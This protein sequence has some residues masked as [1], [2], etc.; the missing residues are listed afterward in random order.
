MKKIVS[1]SPFRIFLHLIIICLLLLFRIIFSLIF[2]FLLVSPFFS[3]S[4]S[5]IRRNLFLLPLKWCNSS[6]LN[7]RLRI[8][9]FSLSFRHFLGSRFSSL[10]LE[11]LLWFRILKHS[12][13]SSFFKPLFDHQ[14]KIRGSIFFPSS[15]SQE[16]ISFFLSSCLWSGSCGGEGRERKGNQERGL[17]S[18]VRSSYII[19]MSTLFVVLVMKSLSDLCFSL[20]CLLSTPIKTK[21][22]PGG[23]NEWS[24]KLTFWENEINKKPALM[25]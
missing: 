24:I 5:R 8:T 19:M 18:V 2:F 11:T 14:L 6:S 23:R 15:F 21:K 20:F 16:Y 10:K 17:R 22:E 13:R 12:F 25:F 3:S 9:F 4:L 7:R 1:S